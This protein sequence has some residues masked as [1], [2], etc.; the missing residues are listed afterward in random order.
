[1]EMAKQF[2]RVA[3]LPY[4]SMPASAAPP[5][6]GLARVF[7]DRGATEVAS[8]SGRTSPQPPGAG[9]NGRYFRTRT[10]VFAVRGRGTKTLAN[11]GACKT[12]Y[13]LYS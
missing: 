13:F 10:P 2:L 9:G 4:A 8:D 11:G 6:G 7:F 5:R 1:M 12:P 3:A